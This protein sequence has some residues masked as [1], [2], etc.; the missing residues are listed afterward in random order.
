MNI[1]ALFHK[2]WSNL[3]CSN[4]LLKLNSNLLSI[5]DKQIEVQ[6][7]CFAQNYMT[8]LLKNLECNAKK[9]VLKIL[10]QMDSFNKVIKLDNLKSCGE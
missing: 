10:S 1:S 9:R 8:S 3:S 5:I 4:K 6:K 7:L 2:V